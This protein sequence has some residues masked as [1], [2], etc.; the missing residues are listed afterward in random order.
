[1]SDSNPILIGMRFAKY[2]EIYTNSDILYICYQTWLE[3]RYAK[4]ILSG[5]DVECDVQEIRE[6]LDEDTSEDEKELLL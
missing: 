4:I 1:M 3:R 2:E 6:L 5:N